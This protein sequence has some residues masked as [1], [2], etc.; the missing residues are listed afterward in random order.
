M[1]ETFIT[2][3]ELRRHTGRVLAAT[4][5]GPVIVTKRGTP[6]FVLLSI[7]DYERLA[8]AARQSEDVQADPSKPP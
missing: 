4:K 7:D 6:A 5:H 8:A 2:A 1:I 3:S